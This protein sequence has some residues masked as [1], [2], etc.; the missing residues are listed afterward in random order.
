MKKIK[1]L[2]F[3][4]PFL[5]YLNSCKKDKTEEP[6]EPVQIYPPQKP[7][8]LVVGYFPSYRSVD[9]VP[10]RMFRMCDVVNYAFADITSSNTASIIDTRKFEQLYQKA[11]ANG[12]KVFLAI[13]GSSDLFGTMS[14]TEQ[15]RTT[16]VKDLMQKVRQY[17]LDGIDMDWEY[18]R[19]SNG[20]K[21]SFTALM[22]QLSDS[23][24]VDGK[25][26]LS[27]AITPGIYAGSVRDGISNEVFN[28][29]DWF[30]VMVY[31]D[32]TTL[33][34][35]QYQQH[36]PYSMVLTSMNYWINTRGMPKD[37]CVLGIP[38]YGRPSGMTQS[39]T[40]LTYSNILSQG[41]DPLSDSA[42]V[43]AAGYTDYK[44]YYNGQ[45]T[46]KKKSAYAKANGGGIMF[47][48]MGQD[49]T[50]DNSL[51]KAAC[52]TLGIRYD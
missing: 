44:I 20:T 1:Y 35:N 12:A 19:S 32:F 33:P 29:A 4:L 39:G 3:L 41:G 37:K 17:K 47:W 18:P 24:H 43:S 27:A 9:A 25:Y 45:P 38:V 10:D 8:F 16:F 28:Y 7:G 51:M 42:I 14:S 52:D 15:G 40:T 36:S 13:G 22:K 21:E 50:N 46:V 5:V 2:L 11:K 30:N 26:Y 6:K 49:A 34:A 31:D 48:E 23:L